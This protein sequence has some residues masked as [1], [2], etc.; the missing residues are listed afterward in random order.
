VSSSI[1]AS[2]IADYGYEKAIEILD[3]FY[4]NGRTF[5]RLNTARFSEEDLLKSIPNAG[6]TDITG[7]YETTDGNLINTPAFVDGM[8]HIQDYS[9]AVACEQLL[10]ADGHSFDILD[11]CSAPGGKSFTLAEKTSGNVFACDISAKRV[12]LIED[13]K[14][15][16]K[17]TNIKTLVQ[18]ARTKNDSLPAFD[19]VLCDVPCS[20]LG[21]IRKKP[22]I[23][24]K[25]TADFTRLSEIQY[26]IL[27][28]GITYLK[29]GGTLLYSTCTLRGDENER[30]IERFLAANPEYTAAMN[31]IFPGYSDGF[32]TAVIKKAKH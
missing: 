11:L 4:Q 17:L 21:V 26:D 15:R 24:Y 30:V 25:D 7:C 5:L 31:T 12:K 16:L 14:E 27:C 1:I 2:F 8:F 23:R 29:P 22:E 32:F 10:P 20:G 3:G 28:T 19:Y 9:C 18:D 6:A 13:G